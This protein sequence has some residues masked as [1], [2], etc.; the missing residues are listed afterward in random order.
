[1]IVPGVTISRI[2]ARRSAGSVPASNATPGPATSNANER[3]A[4]R[5]LLLHVRLREGGEQDLAQARYPVLLKPGRPLHLLH[6]RLRDRHHVLAD[7]LAPLRTRAYEGSPS[8]HDAADDPRR[9]AC[10]AS[11]ERDQF[12]SAAKRERSEVA[13]DPL[14]GDAFDQV[15]AELGGLSSCRRGQAGLRRCLSSENTT[16]GAISLAS[17]PVGTFE[18]F[19]EHSQRHRA[20]PGDLGQPPV[21]L[22][23]DVVGHL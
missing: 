20:G 2:A 10:L 15:D 18:P 9:D 4:A 23:V 19:A 1:M 14:A 11:E 6:R 16:Q 13:G 8:R 21:H 5:G 7:R 12:G 3:E 22:A 17:C